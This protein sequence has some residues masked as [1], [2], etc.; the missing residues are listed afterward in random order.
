MIARIRNGTTNPVEKP[1][2][3]PVG[4][5]AAAGTAVPTAAPRTSSSAEG[6]AAPSATA[7]TIRFLS[8]LAGEVPG[9]VVA[10]LRP[11]E[12]RPR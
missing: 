5:L 3:S 1:A 11:A 10:V 6:M 4:E 8:V 12:C 7:T 2:T 9:I